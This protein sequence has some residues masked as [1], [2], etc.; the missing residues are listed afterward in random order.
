MDQQDSQRR[1]ISLLSLHRPPLSSLQQ[2]TH[3]S[4]DA[5]KTG[6]PLSSAVSKRDSVGDK[7]STYV[8]FGTGLKVKGERV[9]LLRRTFWHGELPSVL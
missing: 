4:L 6:S 7:F 1:R 5:G 2:Q 8:S 9:R 3:S